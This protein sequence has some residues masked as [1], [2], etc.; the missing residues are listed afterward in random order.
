MAAFKLSEKVTGYALAQKAKA[1]C[2]YHVPGAGHIRIDLRSCTQ[3]QA[4]AAFKAGFKYLVK[5]KPKKT[6][7]EASK[8]D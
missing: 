5:E 8:V 6:G 1:V 7:K 3:A 4:D 2:H